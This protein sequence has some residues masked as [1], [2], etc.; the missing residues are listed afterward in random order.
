MVRDRNIELPRFKQTMIICLH[1]YTVHIFA[2]GLLA[3][4]SDSQSMALRSSVRA[5]TLGATIGTGVVGVALLEDLRRAGD[6]VSATIATTRQEVRAHPG[7]TTSNVTRPADVVAT[8][9][10]P[11]SLRGI[12]S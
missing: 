10:I 6:L 5:F 1:Q 9:V 2:I 4:H 3:H 11:N 7:F 8:S 12:A